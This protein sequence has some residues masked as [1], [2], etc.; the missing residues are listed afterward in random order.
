MTLANDMS[1]QRDRNNQNLRVFEIYNFN[2]EQAYP[3]MDK[4]SL[5]VC[6]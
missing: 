1:R 4:T 3:T 2:P 6:S 5:F